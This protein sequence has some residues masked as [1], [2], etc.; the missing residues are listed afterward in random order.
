MKTALDRS[1]RRLLY[2]LFERD[3][4]MSTLSVISAISVTA[5]S[6]AWRVHHH[7]YGVT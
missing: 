5:A 7:H 4:I 1:A 3:L 6:G 2:S